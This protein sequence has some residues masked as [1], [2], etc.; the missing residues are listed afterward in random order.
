MLLLILIQKYETPVK[1]LN[2]PVFSYKLKLGDNGMRQIYDSV[3]RRYV[4]LT[5]EEWVR[6][7]FLNF[8]I[9]NLEYPPGLLGVEVMFSMNNLTRRVDIMAYNRLGNPLLAVECKAPGVKLTPAV[10]D[11]LAEYNMKFRL[12]YLVVTNGI[13]HFS[14]R[15]NWEKGSYSFLEAVPGYREITNTDTV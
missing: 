10:F 4:A 6:Q 12:T 8:M 11:Q 3:R 15:I 13:T 1:E 7:H 2:L 9:N 5:P 14:C